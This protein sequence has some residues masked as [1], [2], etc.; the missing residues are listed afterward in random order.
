MQDNISD[1]HISPAFPFRLIKARTDSNNSKIGDKAYIGKFFCNKRM[2]HNDKNLRPLGNFGV[3]WEYYSNHKTSY[4][5]TP[6]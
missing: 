3:P 4:S 2:G 1:V 5:M 6:I